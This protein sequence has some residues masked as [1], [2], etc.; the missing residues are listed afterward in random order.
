MIPVQVLAIKDT[1]TPLLLE[2]CPAVLSV[3]RRCIEEGYEFR[4]KPYSRNPTFHLPDGT[5]I[6]ME[7]DGY[8]PYIVEEPTPPSILKHS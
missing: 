5:V 8:V 7:V 2:S 1:V 4:W 3:G 6:N